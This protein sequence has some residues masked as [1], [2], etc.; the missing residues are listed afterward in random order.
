[1]IEQKNLNMENLPPNVEN[2]I[3]GGRIGIIANAIAKKLNI[4]SI[5]ALELFFESEACNNFHDKE[6]GLYLFSELYIAD[7]FLLE[8]QKKCDLS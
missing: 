5:E 7:E 6:T 8:Y 2:I 4:N 3:V 1:M